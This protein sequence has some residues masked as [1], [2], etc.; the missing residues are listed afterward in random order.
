MVFPESFWRSDLRF[1]RVVTNS[2]AVS[3]YRYRGLPRVQCRS[4]TVGKPPLTL[5]LA[6]WTW[7]A[8]SRRSALPARAVKPSDPARRSDRCA[9]P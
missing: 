5:V 3:N 7:S 1:L 4:L 9:Q 2:S 6:S 8:L